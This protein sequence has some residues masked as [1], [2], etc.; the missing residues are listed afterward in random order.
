MRVRV[1]VRDRER[2][3][4]GAAHQ[5]AQ[6]RLVR[7]VQ[8]LVR[9]RSRVGARVRVRVSLYRVVQDLGRG[10]ARAAGVGT[11]W[12]GA[13]DLPQRRGC[14]L[15]RVRRG[16]GAAPAHLVGLGE[17]D[18]GVGVVAHVLEVLLVVRALHV[19]ADHADVEVARDE[20]HRALA[21]LA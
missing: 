12:K 2:L 3:L 21:P 9:V 5:R 18:G 10:T 13:G 20:R 17:A 6:P 11:G 1:R 14:G 7:V 15:A 4:S 16:E 19:G 8:D